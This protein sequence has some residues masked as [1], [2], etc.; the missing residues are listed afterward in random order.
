MA[1][2]EWAILCDYTFKDEQGKICVIGIFD[3]IVAASVPTKQHQAAIV[4][5]FTGNADEK[6][7]FKV[8][9]VRPTG[10]LLGTITGESKLDTSGTLEVNLNLKELPL[11]DWG[12]YV[13]SIYANDAPAKPLTFTVDKPTTLSGRRPGTGRRGPDHPQE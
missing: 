5:K 7:K 8:E 3:R 11:P 12:P 2:C 1:V 13:F 6:V 9:I 10:G 4:M